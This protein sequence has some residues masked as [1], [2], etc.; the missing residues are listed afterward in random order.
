MAGESPHSDLPQ[1]AL[2]NA[3][4]LEEQLRRHLEDLARQT[5]D[6][7]QGVESLRAALAAAARVARVLGES[8]SEPPPPTQGC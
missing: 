5:P 2:E 1:L 8:K 3:R 7:A 6:D 4:R